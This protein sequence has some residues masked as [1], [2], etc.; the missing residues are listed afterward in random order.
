MAYGYASSPSHAGCAGLLASAPEAGMSQ[1][2]TH[3]CH[4]T[5]RPSRCDRYTAKAGGMSRGDTPAYA[6]TPRSTRPPSLDH[7]CRRTGHGSV[8]KNKQRLRK[9]SLLAV[10]ACRRYGGTAKPS[11][12]PPGTRQLPPPEEISTGISSF[13]GSEQTEQEQPGR[14]KGVRNRAQQLH[15]SCPRPTALLQPTALYTPRR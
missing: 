3:L 12:S 8:I 13:Q 10:Q 14:V 4:R 11:Q 1:P 9:S 7:T 2:S 6:R 5:C 15:F